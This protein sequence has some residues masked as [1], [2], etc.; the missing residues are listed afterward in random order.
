MNKDQQLQQLREEYKIAP[1]D[2][3]REIIVRRARALNFKKPEPY[4][5]EPQPEV[6]TPVFASTGQ[7]IIL[8][9]LIRK[10]RIELELSKIH[11]LSFEEANQV[12]KEAGY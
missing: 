8:T 11:Q 3:A 12:I 6:K 1:D 5:P 4:I 7:K 10:E 2:T 9:T